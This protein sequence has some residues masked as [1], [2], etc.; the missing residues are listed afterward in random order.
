VPVLTP[1]FRPIYRNGKPDAKMMKKKDR[2]GVIERLNSRETDV[3]ISTVGLFSTGIDIA[4]LEVLIL[5]SPIKSEIKLKQALGRIMR[6]TE[7]T[8]SPVFIDLVDKRVE[9]LRGQARTRK[10][11][12]E[13][14]IDV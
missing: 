11:I 1:D 14:A 13:K 12:I 6:K 3:I 2:E 10:K 5:A 9:L 4:S 8:K 7:N